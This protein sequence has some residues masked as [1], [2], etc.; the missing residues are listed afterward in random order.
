MF[1]ECDR[2]SSYSSLDQSCGRSGFLSPRVGRVYGVYKE[3]SRGGRDR[4]WRE[5]CCVT[6]HG[7]L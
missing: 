1:L 2:G 3:E 4:I 7:F 6:L 5:E